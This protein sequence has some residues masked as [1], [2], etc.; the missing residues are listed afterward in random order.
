MTR[1]TRS[2]RSFR[3]S[4]A[5]VLS[6][7]ALFLALAGSALALPQNTVRS[8]QIVN[9][10]IRT[11]DIRDNAVKTA[12]IANETITADDLGTDSVNSDEVAENAIGS[13]EVAPESLTTADLG[14]ASVSSS[15][16]AD[17]SLT[18][19]DLGPGSV[20]ASELGTITVRTN[21]APLKV[22]ESDGVTVSCL[23]GEQV[24]S[25]GGQGGHY[26]V[27]TTGTRPSGNG[28]RFLAVNKTAATDST[29]TAYA[30]CLGA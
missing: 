30:V 7:A 21:S 16:V 11:V 13:P 27:E 8:P 25:G 22:G 5:L 28:W 29:I 23:A 15:E 6:C 20:G 17:Q 2:T 18:S 24:I 4:P 14:A 1:K 9:G 26:G 12:K 10:T 19:S 3:P